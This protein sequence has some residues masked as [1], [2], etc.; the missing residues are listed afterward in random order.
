MRLYT[1][2]AR[3]SIKKSA[4]NNQNEITFEND[5][6]NKEQDG[7]HKSRQ[8]SITESENKKLHKLNNLIR[9]TI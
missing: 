6:K 2:K 8:L 7:N 3:L 9:V 1:N 5:M 4:D